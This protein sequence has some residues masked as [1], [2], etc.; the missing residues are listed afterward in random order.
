MRKI[1][2]SFYSLVLQCA[3]LFFN[4]YILACRLYPPFG[5]YASRILNVKNNGNSLLFTVS[6]ELVIISVLLYTI[7]HYEGLSRLK[8]KSF[9]RTTLAVFGLLVVLVFIAAIRIDMIITM[10]AVP[11]L[12]YILGI[13]WLLTFMAQV[14]PEI[15]KYML[16]E[17]AEYDKIIEEKIKSE[18]FKTEL[19]TN[20]S[21]DIK[22]PL[23]SIINYIDLIKRLKI[24]NESLDEYIEI[25]DKKSERL[26]MLINDLL[27]ASKAGTGNVTVNMQEIDLV[28]L[29][30]QIA[31]EFDMSFENA[32]L[33]FVFRHSEDKIPIM[34]DSRHI[35]RV[36]ENIFGNAI[37]YAMPGTRIY[38]DISKEKGITFSLKNISKEPLGIS[39]DELMEQFVRG[40]RSRHSEGSGLGLYIAKSLTELMGMRF[41]IFVSGDLFEVV[42][43]II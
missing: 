24:Q 39:A 30:G 11:V 41:E 7:W 14:K 36:M 38:A 26:K 18:R 1:L 27:E 42:I 19:I 32:K 8:R 16:I 5:Y 28:E 12:M 3:L 33:E 31:G 4:T 23:T 9:E 37:K 34:A 29:T 25:L 10:L 13:L 17:N 35:C 20:V 40:D 15:S 43:K 21:H 2:L 22:T 6:L